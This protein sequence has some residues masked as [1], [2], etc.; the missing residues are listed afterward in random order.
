MT[1]NRLRECIGD[2]VKCFYRI[3]QYIECGVL[4]FILGKELIIPK[5]LV[6]Y[7]WYLINL[8]KSLLLEPLWVPTHII[9]PYLNANISGI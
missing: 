4:E 5:S 6:S 3:R 1:F 2:T 7:N 8:H 9:I